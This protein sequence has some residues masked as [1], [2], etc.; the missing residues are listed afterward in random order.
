M[1]PPQLPNR[2]RSLTAMEM[3]V[4]SHQPNTYVIQNL[5]DKP[6]SRKSMEQNSQSFAQSASVNDTEGARV[7]DYSQILSFNT[8]LKQRPSA[9]ISLSSADP[10]LPQN[11]GTSPVQHHTAPAIPSS[12]S[13]SSSSSSSSSS[14]FHARV[15]DMNESVAAAYEVESLQQKHHLTNSN[16]NH[17][18]TTVTKSAVFSTKQT[19]T[20]V[21]MVAASRTEK[22][23]SG[24]QAA[25][26]DGDTRPSPT[27]PVTPLATT[28]RGRKFQNPSPPKQPAPAVFASPE[29][30]ATSSPSRFVRRRH[31]ASPSRHSSVPG[32]SRPPADGRQS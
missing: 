15:L 32:R 28:P 13:C 29:A 11:R 30:A 7:A 12:S 1:P 16:S 24:I 9:A 2:A 5:D 23:G 6:N 27:M 4:P 17:R 25:G 31:R 10:P 3:K 14:S 19:E 21:G 20:A 8:P 26:S 22:L 18:T